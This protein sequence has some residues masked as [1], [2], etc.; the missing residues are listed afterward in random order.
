M[1]IDNDELGNSNDGIFEEV[2]TQFDRLFQSK[3][4]L[5]R[6]M[7]QKHIQKLR[8]LDEWFPVSDSF[9]MIINSATRKFE[10]ITKNFEGVTGLNR[11]KME[12][13]GMAYWWSNFKF[14]ELQSGMVLLADVIKFIQQLSEEDK[15]RVKYNWSARVKTRS[16]QWINFLNNITP[17]VFDQKG[18]PIINLCYYTRIGDGHALPLQIIAKRLND[19]NE[20]EVIWQRNQAKELLM[21]PLSDRELDVVRELARGLSS[22]QIGDKLFISSHTVDTHRRRILSKLSLPSTAALIAHYKAAL[23]V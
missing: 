13:F 20:Y 19:Q 14:M 8:E 23:L 9:F 22:K 15:Y 7:V 16:G 17:L 4:E 2:L 1:G 12:R 18:K 6:T 11:K 21:D 10:Y 5:Q 3:D